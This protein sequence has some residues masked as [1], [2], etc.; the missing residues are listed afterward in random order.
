MGK[1]GGRPRDTLTVGGYVIQMCGC[2]ESH[3]ISF[4]MHAFCCHI[5][6]LTAPYH[7]D[8]VESA[9]HVAAFPY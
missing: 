6:Q 3:L 2:H 4:D 5:N 9:F 7:V 8:N 1:Q